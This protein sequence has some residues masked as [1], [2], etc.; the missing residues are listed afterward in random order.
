MLEGQNLPGAE[1]TAGAR[2]GILLPLALPSP[3]AGRGFLPSDGGPRIASACPGTSVAFINPFG[4]A[5]QSNLPSFN[6]GILS[7]YYGTGAALGSK[8]HAQIIMNGPLGEYIRQRDSLDVIPPWLIQEPPAEDNT[9]RNKVF[10]GGA[11]IN[12]EDAVFGQENVPETSKN[13]FVAYKALERINALVEYAGTKQGETQMFSLQKRF[14]AWTAELKE[15]IDGTKFEG[16]TM[17]SGIENSSLKSII[18]RKAADP[19]DLALGLPIDD[20]FISS[21]V[22]SVRADP[23]SG[24]TGTETFTMSVTENGVTTDLVADLADATSLTIDGV[25]EYLSDLLET[26]GFGTRI[27]VERNK[28][29]SYSLE[30]VTSEGETL[31]FTNPSDPETAVYTAG[32]TSAGEF[33]NGFLAKHDDVLTADPTQAVYNNIFTQGPDQARAVAVDSEGYVYALGTTKGEL[34]KQ[35]ATGVTDI[36]LNKYDQSGRLVSTRMVGAARDAT[37]FAMAIDGDDNVV[38]AGQAFGPLSATANSSNP[39]F[40]DSFVMKFDS[41]GQELWT[42]QTAPYGADGATALTTDAAGNVYVA[43]FVSGT[44][45][46]GQVSAGARDAYLTKLD[47]GGSLVYNQQFGT[48]ASDIANAIV[49]D[50]AGG[51]FLAGMNGSDGFLRKYDDSGGTPVLV[52]EN[53]LGDLGSG[54][55]IGGIVRDAAANLY[56]AGTTI[57]PALHGTVKNGHS[58]LLDGFVLKVQ[59]NG[60]SGTSQWVTYEGTAGDDEVHGIALDSAAGNDFYVVGTTDGLF[61]GESDDASNY[62]TFFARMDSDGVHEMVQQFGGSSDHRGL[63]LAIDNQGTSVLSRLGLPT[64]DLFPD[65]SRTIVSQTT[66]RAGQYFYLEVN[67]RTRTRVTLEAND[68]WRSL[69]TRVNS[70]LGVYGKA[71]VKQSGDVES[72]VITAKNGGDIVIRPGGDGHN[73]LPGLG[74]RETRL[75]APVPDTGDE[76]ALKRAKAARFSLGLADSMTIATKKGREEAGVLFSGALVEIKDAYR[77]TTV[78]YEEDKPDIGPAPPD[79]ALKIARYKDAL[80]RISSLAPQGGGGGLFG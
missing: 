69:A 20:V 26:A 54:G 77:F 18:E 66:A 50:G 46:A 51:V 16:I 36:F 28:E 7:A 15:F 56:V 79:M 37:G 23:I 53:N 19:V 10:D 34:D 45:A 6:M 58:G 42:R 76:D 1:R 11:L 3:R 21:K 57:N 35:V 8:M 64:G 63:A 73:A 17:L 38:I 27:Q 65:D 75:L 59:D 68:S 40:G 32:R 13:L 74:L 49:V 60:A 43:G 62:D 5:P 29:D 80:A 4:S 72:L 61:P 25:T 39:A 55:G 47:D 9:L 41:S 52:Y 31:S 24:L 67:G 2:G 22:A 30:I 48:A 70:A 14:D 12:H 33:T 44:L 78:G 71:Q